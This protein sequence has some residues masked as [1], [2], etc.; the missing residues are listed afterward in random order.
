M[1]CRMGGVR[2]GGVE[3]GAMVRKWSSESL[4]GP[5]LFRSRDMTRMGA[6]LDADLV[7][8]LELGRSGSCGSC[9]GWTMFQGQKVG[10]H[11]SESTPYSLRRS[12]RFPVA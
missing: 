4:I 5:V 1:P 2:W 9:G 10:R 11:I 6:A 7:V 12:V 8:G 3:G